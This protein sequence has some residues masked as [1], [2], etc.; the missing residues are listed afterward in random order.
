MKS[1]TTYF[2]QKAASSKKELFLFDPHTN[3]TFS[4]NGKVRLTFELF[5]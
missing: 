5:V 3:S 1:V 2:V 4:K